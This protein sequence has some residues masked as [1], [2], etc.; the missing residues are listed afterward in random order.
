MIKLTTSLNKQ[1]ISN[2][3]VGDEVLLSGTIFTARDRAYNVLLEKN[4]SKI[5]DQIIYHSGLIIRET[6]NGLQ[7]ISAGP[8]TSARFIERS[9]KLI[10]KYKIKAFIGKGG[11]DTPEIIE[12]FEKNNV[13][14]FA[15]V[16]GAGV[17]YANAIVK[18]KNAYFRNL[19]M[20][21][22]VLELEVKDFPV[23]VTMDSHGNSIY[24][25]VYKKSKSKVRKYLK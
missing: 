7:P 5:K 3:H 23:V 19:G 18:I 4:F 9:I 16:G 22:S 11:M 13:V 8:T 21:D 25:N 10:K 15:A 20:T 24:N 2:L 17:L 1:D 6:K 14:Y 12:A